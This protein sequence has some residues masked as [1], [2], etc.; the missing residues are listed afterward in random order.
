MRLFLFLLAII[1]FLGASEL[2]VATLG[3]GQ[4]AIRNYFTIVTLS[5][6]NARWCEKNLTSLLNQD[7]D[8]YDVV[9]VD[10]ASTDGTG[11]L[12]E[13]Y[14][15]GHPQKNRIRLVHN[16]VNQGALAN[17]YATLRSIP[18]DHIVV[19]VDG[20]DSLEGTDVLSKLNRYYNA[21]DAWLTYGQHRFD[22]WGL[23]GHTR[24][25]TRAFLESQQGRSDTWFFSHV[26][27]FYA[28]LFKKIRLDD[29]L[30]EDTFFPITFDLAVMY[31]MVEMAGV[32]T[33]FVSDI[34]YN[35]NTINP[36]SDFRKH[37][38]L[39]R[40]ME[41]VIR[42]KARYPRVEEHPSVAVQ[43][44]AADIIAF[45]FNRP[46]QLYSLLES[47]EK[48]VKGVNTT[49]VIYRCTEEKY[50]QGYRE[51]KKRFPE[52]RFR[53]QSNDKEIA[54]T[55]YKPWVLEALGTEEGKANYVVF[56][57]DDI[58][59]IGDIDI[60]ADVKALKETGGYGFF[61]RLGIL[62]DF[63]FMENRAARQPRLISVDYQR[64]AWRFGRG[65]C[66]WKYPHTVDFTIYKKSD[67]LRFHQ[68]ADY[69]YPNDH[70]GGWAATALHDGTLSKLGLCP[71][72]QKIVNIPLNVVSHYGNNLQLN[73]DSVT[74]LP[75][76]I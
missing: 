22:P 75:Q 73:I 13:S 51:V 55:Q 35:Y 33:Y 11:E 17:L 30:E 6:N 26:R 38:D 10:D 68:N 65:D 67:I 40:A 37:L 56:A 42:A 50:E 32:H 3:N 24:P 54:Y 44:E 53:R 34:L 4:C 43:G 12:V 14:V 20:D 46:M 2:N 57:V 29:L 31:P 39:Q 23:I 59:V 36:I 76:K 72:F 69:H 5:Y 64:F 21:N 1:G 70:E 9:Y 74:E 25:V 15:N 61:Y 52:V 58:I 66:E 71:Q 41:K 60:A 62:N 63:S 27:T 19:L 47:V 45:S 16:R 18:D 49:T 7:Y 28:G 48:R 8:N